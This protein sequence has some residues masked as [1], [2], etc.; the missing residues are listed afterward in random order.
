MPENQLRGHRARLFLQRLHHYY[1]QGVAEILE[2]VTP[3]KATHRT[4]KVPKTNAAKPNALESKP[5]FLPAPEEVE[6]VTDHRRQEPYTGPDEP[7]SKGPL[8]VL[9]PD[10]PSPAE[11]TNSGTWAGSSLPWHKETRATSPNIPISTP[12]DTMTY[13]R[14]A[15]S[16]SF[17][18][19][20]SSQQVHELEA[21]APTTLGVRGVTNRRNNIQPPPRVSN[22]RSTGYKETEVEC[23]RWSL[24]KLLEEIV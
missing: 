24:Y 15:T 18:S 5:P 10:P 12:V 1:R 19:V 11:T 14:S 13:S 8:R 17:S 22:R 23:K 21:S 20:A 6:P 2:F 3:D 7:T 4:P 9:N 16:I